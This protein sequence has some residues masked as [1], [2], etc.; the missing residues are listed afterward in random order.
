MKQENERVVIMRFTVAGDPKSQPRPRFIKGAVVSTVSPEVSRWQ[1]SV[2]WGASEAYRACG[3][4]NAFTGVSALRVDCTFWFETKKSER[5]GRPH[6]HKPDRDN[7]DK[8]VLDACVKVSAL[9]GDDCRVSAGLI[10]KRWCRPGY[11]GLLVEVSADT[12]TDTGYGIS[13]ESPEAPEWLQL[14]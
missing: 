14:G 13:P 5:W 6:T 7:L 4:E 1:E 3:G 9:A 2:K 11:S 10:R 12:D 8:L